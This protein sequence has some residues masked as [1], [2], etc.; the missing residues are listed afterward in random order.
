G[1]IRADGGA[2]PGPSSGGGASGGT[3]ALNVG[4]WAG[5]GRIT[6]AGGINGNGSG[7]G[8]GGGGR[9]AVRYTTRSYTG[10]LEAPGGARFAGGCCAGTAGTIFL[11][12]NGQPNGDLIVDGFNVPLVNGVFLANNTGTT[13]LA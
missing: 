10:T 12:D 2:A 7:S 8:A 6:A 9:I 11:K 13:L 1:E 3:V 5:S 4:T